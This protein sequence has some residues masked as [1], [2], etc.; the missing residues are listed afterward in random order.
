MRRERWSSKREKK[1]KVTEGFFFH[2]VENTVHLFGW[3]EILSGWCVQ[4]EP[5]VMPSGEMKA[6]ASVWKKRK[7]KQICQVYVCKLCIDPPII[8][9]FLVYRKA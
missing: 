1:E 3:M 6:L 4:C 2:V 7:Q 9:L 5:A 8:A